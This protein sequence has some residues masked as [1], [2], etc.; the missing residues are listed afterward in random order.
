MLRGSGVEKIVG[1]GEDEGVGMPLRAGLRGVGK[2]AIGEWAEGLG[3]W[4]YT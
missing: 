4:V 1:K 3:E 2:D